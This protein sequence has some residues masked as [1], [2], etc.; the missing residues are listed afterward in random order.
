[1]AALA[2]LPFLAAALVCLGLAFILTLL[3]YALFKAA[4]ELLN[5]IPS[6]NIGTAWLDGVVQAVSNALG[7]A[8]HGI[9]HLIG[10][11]FHNLARLTGRLWSEFKAH[12]T[13]LAAIAGPVG[14][15][16]EA[17]YG[18]RALVHHLTHGLAH[19]LPR[20]KALEKEWHGIE[21]GVRSFER[22]IDRL[23][24]RDVLPE[25][26]SLE[27]EVNAIPGELKDLRKW[28]TDHALIAGTGAMVGAVAWALTRLGL[29]WIKCDSAKSFF[30]RAG[31]GFW[32]LL[33]DALAILA[34]IA[35]AVFSVLRPQ[36]LAQVAVDAVDAIEPILADILK[37]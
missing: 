29:D 4:I 35:L 27:G 25:I 23:I 36:E 33:E 2:E 13:L 37:N 19:T 26:R 32:K 31:C 17:Y 14:F 22:R 9:D 3:V 6:V 10:W 1:M 5:K 28:V 30:K 11:Q 16:V 18:I 21:H 8:F 15:L 20:I 7:R 34:T 24:H 12:A